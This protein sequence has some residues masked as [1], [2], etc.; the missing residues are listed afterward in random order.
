ME[1]LLPYLIVSLAIWAAERVWQVYRL[2][3]HYVRELQANIEQD[4]PLKG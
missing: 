2:T 3:G 1:V 4:R